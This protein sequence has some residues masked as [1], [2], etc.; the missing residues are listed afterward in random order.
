MA[1]PRHELSYVLPVRHGHEAGCDLDEYVR[2]LAPRVDLWV[3]DGSEAP[4]HEAHLAAWGDVAVRRPEPQYHF[5]NGKVDGVM[6]GLALARHE[7]V[8][9]ADDD[10]RYDDGSLA[11]MASRLDRAHAVR[12]QNYF[13]P[14]PWHAQWDTAR[15][16]INRCFGADYPGTLGVRR[17][18]LLATGGYDGDAMF[19]NLELMRTVRAAGGIVDSPADLFVARIPP[20]LRQF[21]SQRV[22]EAYDDFAQPAR[23]AVSLAALPAAVAAAR[24]WGAPR[25][26]VTV[27]SAAIAAAAV[28]RARAG[29]RRRFPASAALFAPAWVA[30]R[31]VCSWLAV[32]CRLVLGGV[33]YR[34]G[35]LP[36]AANSTRRIRRRLAAAV[37]PHHLRDAADLEHPHGG[38]AGSADDNFGAPPFD[39]AGCAHDGAEPGGVDELELGQ[40]EHDVAGAATVHERGQGVVEGRSRVKV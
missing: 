10:V 17:S 40:V 22:R 25:V 34:G 11:E 4:V 15:T 39:R 6:T 38:R 31:A 19:E 13:R 23:L 30:E 36:L 29:G 35:V 16:L 18:L 32:G 7:R 1:V 24:L 37:D 8:I 9:V 21:R 2:W 27:A 5:K 14:V 28:G 20:T 33:P 26:A 3:I 12:P